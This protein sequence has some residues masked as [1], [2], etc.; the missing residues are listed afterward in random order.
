MICR[1]V[2]SLRVV[3]CFVCRSA[4]GQ[5]TSPSRACRRPSPRR[6]RRGSRT[7]TSN[8]PGGI[9]KTLTALLIVLLTAAPASATFSIVAF[10]PVTGD[11]GV[12]VASRV[13]AVG[14]HVPWAEAGVGA[15]ATQ[16]SMN[17]GYGPRGLELLRQ[18][19]TAQQV[20]EPLLAEDRFH[21]IEG[22][23]VG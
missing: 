7:R 23:P 17:G 2:R 10:D 19:L 4:T 16:A 1:S 18:G 9:V 6:S 12:A 13:F 14:N 21:R 5:S 15:V 3:R 11:L 22:R 20:L 8:K